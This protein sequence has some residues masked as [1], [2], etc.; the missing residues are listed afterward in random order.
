MSLSDLN[1]NPKYRAKLVSID[2]EI[3]FRPFTVGEQKALKVASEVGDNKSTLTAVIDTL[4]ACTYNNI[5]IENLPIFDIETLFLKIRAVSVGDAI[6]FA[7]TCWSCEEPNE[8]TI[9]ITDNI[10]TEIQENHNKEVMITDNVK[11]LF[12]YPTLDMNKEIVADN[13][14]DSTIETIAACISKVYDMKNER[15]YDEESIAEKV[16][17]VNG[18]AMDQ[19]KKIKEEFFDT[20]PKNKA[21]IKF[22]CKK[23]E[24]ENE[25]TINDSESFFT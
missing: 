20:M 14:D 5:E 13:D 6:D 21:I 8:L 4:K 11:L 12:Q 9:S 7:I 22:K 3:I 2:E 16:K 15:V 18:L 23:C 24:A 10:K 19:V 1:V 25:R 17:F